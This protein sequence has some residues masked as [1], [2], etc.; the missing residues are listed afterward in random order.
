MLKIVLAVLLP[1][2]A[3]FGYE[4]RSVPTSG[5]DHVQTRDSG[6]L[7][8]MIVDS[9]TVTMDVDLAR[10]SVTRRPEK[11]RQ[12]TTALHF[13]VDRESFFT[14]LAFNGE[15][16]GPLPS[17]MGLI[18]EDLSALPAKLAASYRQL[19]LESVGWGSQYDLVVRDSK[20]GFVFFNIEGQ[21]FDYNSGRHSISINT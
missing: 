18:P 12:Q 20:T 2:F 1:I 16:R 15:L 14:L 8:K 7:E 19:V 10:F 9:G 6:T 5:I 13:T 21:Q 17:T 11:P 4:S 3:F